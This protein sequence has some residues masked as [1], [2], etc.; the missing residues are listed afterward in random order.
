M[1]SKGILLIDKP[2][3]LTSHDVVAVIRKKLNVKKVG[4]TGTLDPLA[5]GLLIILIGR[6]YTKKQ[7]Q[8]LKKDKQY[9][10]TIKLGVE[11]DSYDSDGK[12]VKRASPADLKKITEQDLVSVLKKFQGEINQAVP[13]FS[14]VKIKGKKLYQL[15]RQKR[16]PK[17]LPVKT[18]TINN[19]KLISFN[20]QTS[21][22]RLLVDCSSGTY[23]RSLAHDIGKVLCVGAHVTKL[24][25]TK[26]GNLS[27][28]QA[29]SLEKI[30]SA[31]NL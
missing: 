3:G 26:I 12:I 16:I 29:V 4:H 25:R 5:T 15:A 6:Q 27:V 14:A 30:S 9:Q 21:E 22:A 23:I 19:L 8:F 2:K 13:S 7:D 18:V 1:T 28:D 10:V 20:N 24:R 17:K 11:T 31:P